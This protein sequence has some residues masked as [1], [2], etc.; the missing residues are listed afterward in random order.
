MLI[1][2]KVAD[3]MNAQIGH[4]VGA[5]MQYLQIATYFD[6]NALKKLAEFFYKQSEEEREF[7]HFLTEAGAEAHIPPIEAPKYDIS[8]AEQAFQMSVD[9]EVEVTGQIHN[10]VEMATKERDYASLS[11][12]QWFV[13]E[14]VEEVSS[15]ETMLQIVQ[16]SGEKN[17]LMVEAYLTHNA[18]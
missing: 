17:L 10:I 7:I 1:S 13:N 12:L 4:E 8:S 6:L 2:K 18:A 15:M 5:S 11:F 14:Q 3:L 16:L 9:W